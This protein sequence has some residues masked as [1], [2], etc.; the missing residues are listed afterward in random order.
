MKILGI[1]EAGRGPVLGP[2][3]ITGV[4][5]S[6]DQIPI[7]ERIGVKDSKR[8][9][10]KKR[11]IIARK[12]K[13]FGK[14]YTV[15]ISASKI[16]KQRS[17]GV[18]LNEIEMMAIVKIIDEARPDKVIVDSIDVKPHRFEKRI[19]RFVDDKIIVRAEHGADMKYYPVAAAS[20]I[21]KVKRDFEM[22]KLR[23]RYHSRLGSGYPN[24]P[25]TKA[26]LSKFSREE[27]PKFVRKS[28]KTVEKN[29]KK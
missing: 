21:A 8:L 12:I 18:N 19:K 5:M 24:D 20:I 16:D 17:M 1:D 23:R 22:E 11:T 4:M 15:K 3:I 7:L 28:W 14:C 10:P 27:L 29:L 26:F 25:L 13:K 9:S 2:L 6:H